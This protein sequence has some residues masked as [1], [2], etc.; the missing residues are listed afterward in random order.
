MSHRYPRSGRVDASHHS[1]HH[2]NMQ[3]SAL[4]A[5]SQLLLVSVLLTSGCGGGG[6]GGGGACRCDFG[7]SCEQYSAGCGFIECESNGMNAY[8]SGS[9]SLDDA[10]GKCTCATDS[11]VTYYRSDH[12]DPEEDCDFFCDNGV[13]EAL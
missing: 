5:A 1:G 10:V 7:D 2:G 3:L 6:G 11:M 12:P 8:A 9:C 13:Y 4:L